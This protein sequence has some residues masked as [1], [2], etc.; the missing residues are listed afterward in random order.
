MKLEKLSHFYILFFRSSAIGVKAIFMLLAARALSS[1]Q[2][3]EFVVFLSN[4][5]ILLSLLGLNLNQ[6][7]NRHL[8]N[9]H[10]PSSLITDHFISVGLTGLILLTLVA[11]LGPT[12]G[13]VN[14]LWFFLGIT[15]L[16]HMTNEAYFLLLP[17]GKPLFANIVLFL[18]VMGS[19]GLICLYFFF[20]PNGKSD[21]STI[22]TIWITSSLALSIFL[23]IKYPPKKIKTIE[24]LRKGWK[25]GLIY[26]VISVLTKSFYNL[27]KVFLSHSQN[28]EVVGLYGM[29]FSI[30]WTIHTLVEA[31]LIGPSIKDFLQSPKDNLLLRNLVIK[32]ISSYGVLWLILTFCLP[33]ITRLLNKPELQ[34]MSIFL[35]LFLLA[36]FLYSVCLCFSMKLYVI[37]KDHFILISSILS[38]GVFIT[39]MLTNNSTGL[40]IATNIIIVSVCYLTCLLS[41]FYF[42]ANRQEA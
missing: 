42:D 4:M 31:S 11:F 9:H 40:A 28:L 29:M 20:A 38:F 12:L 34:D 17:M 19:Y 8:S 32:V 1:H 10:S 25:V 2:Y 22:F 15:F 13:I 5:A 35:H 39:C 7:T 18:K 33:L 37:Q 27:D 30:A 3:G 24:V 36:G 16:E 23:L 6:F 26:L 21:L 14:S 41:F